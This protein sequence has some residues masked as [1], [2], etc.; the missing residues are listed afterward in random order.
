MHFREVHA[1]LAELAR[2]SDGETNLP[3]ACTHASAKHKD[4]TFKVYEIFGVIQSSIV[5]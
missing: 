1:W 3:R 2:R 5:P 4:R